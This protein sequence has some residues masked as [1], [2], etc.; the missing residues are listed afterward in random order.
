M[1]L[2]Y[3]LG[4]STTSGATGGNRL[5]V[6]PGVIR[7]WPLLHGAVSL[8]GGNL[9]HRGLGIRLCCLLFPARASDNTV[10]KLNYYSGCLFS[11][12]FGPTQMNC[13]SWFKSVSRTQPLGSNPASA[14]WYFRG[15]TEMTC[16]RCASV[17]SK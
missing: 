13:P 10:E 5:F 15:P 7:R 16:P 11:L 2:L 14:S 3:S 17:S 6:D 12:T 8:M 4:I 1:V 9:K